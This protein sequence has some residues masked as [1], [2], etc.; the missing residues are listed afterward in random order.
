VPPA[1]APP[2]AASRLK[3]AVTR[4]VP[5]HKTAAKETVKETREAPKATAAASAP[6]PARPDTRL[7]ASRPPQKPSVFDA[8]PATAS[9]QI[10][11]AAPVV[12][13]SSF[14]SRFSA[15]K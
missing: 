1:P 6:E 2:S 13:S 11:G 9:G 4:F 8:A 10:A 3:A 12:Q 7:A 15:M 5:G 14:D